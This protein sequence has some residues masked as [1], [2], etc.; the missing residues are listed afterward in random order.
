MAKKIRGKVCHYVAVCSS[1]DE[2]TAAT[3]AVARRLARQYD[4]VVYLTCPVKTPRGTRW[5]RY[6]VDQ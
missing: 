5:R 1:G 3:K 2:Y 6:H 4:G